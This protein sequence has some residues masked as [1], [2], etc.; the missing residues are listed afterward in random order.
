[1][2]NLLTIRNVAL[3]DAVTLEFGPGLNLLTGETGSGKS[4]IVDALSALTG[5]RA[6][7]EI[8]KEGSDSAEIEGL[9][10]IAD[11]GPMRQTLADAGIETDS[12]EIIV[13]REILRSGRNR[14]FINDR[15]VTA[16]FLRSIGGL[17]VN[18]FGQGESSSLFEPSEHRELLDDFAGLGNLRR[19]VAA[20]FA[21]LISARDRVRSLERDESERLQLI[22]TLG[23]QIGEISSV[24]PDPEEVQRLEEEKRRL[25]NIGKLTELSGEA[26]SLLYENDESTLSTFD[27]ACKRIE[28]LAEFDPQFAAY[29]EGLESA[30]AVLEDLAF[31]VREFSAGLEFSPGRLDEIESRL[32]EINRIARKYGGSVESALAHLSEARERLAAIESSETAKMQ[33]AEELLRVR[34]EYLE[35]A[36]K[37][38]AERKRAA[39]EYSRAVT[40]DLK[41]VALEKAKFEV[42]IES[43][44]EDA[45]ND[46]NFGP[47]GIDRV[48]FYFSANPGEAPKPLA[49]IASG[50]EASRLM[51]ILKTAAKAA[52]SGQTMVFDEVDAGIG[53]RVAEAVGEKLRSLAAGGQILCVTHQPQVASKADRHFVVEKNFVRGKTQIS[54]RLLDETGRIEEIARMLAGEKITAAARAN[55]REMIAAAT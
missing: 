49:K 52:T 1:M 7:V 33:A 51:L 5:G 25:A 48:E 3:I 35:S 15:L 39:A 53:G 42:R 12:G 18:I 17:L 29:R 10:S 40:R 41:A 4:I 36:L 22:D 16:S 28:E 32:A 6:L 50:G 54:V 27:R 45:A 14:I 44:A 30:R 55:A 34:T 19:E 2:L 26:L 11:G 8:I 21:E 31:T 43:A 24:N 23:F 38:S 20:K 47:S 37:L 9:F 46:A 13:R